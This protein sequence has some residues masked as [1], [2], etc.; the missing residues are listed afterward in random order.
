MVCVEPINGGLGARISGLAQKPQDECGF[1]CEILGHLDRYQLLVFPR[2]SASLPVFRA[3]AQTLGRLIRHDFVS[4]PDG[5]CIHEIYKRPEDQ[6][7]FGGV[8][9]SDGAYLE[10]PP[11]AIMLQAVDVPKHG[12]DTLFAC[13]FAAYDTLP[14]LLKTRFRDCQVLHTAASVF[15]EHPGSRSAG[16]PQSACHPLVRLVPGRGDYA[17]FHSGPCAQEVIGV[18]GEESAKLLDDALSAATRSP[19]QYRHEWQAGD[20]VIWDNRSTMHKALN[21][22]PGQ[23]RQMRRA[24]I[25]E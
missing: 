16:A 18:T 17:L 1:R 21:D 7:N 23:T 4:K 10:Q 12:G 11:R 20:I 25:A 6:Q 2:Y 5:D 13:Q 14:D 19:L 24:M 22:Y 3:L 9:H 15:G 8:W